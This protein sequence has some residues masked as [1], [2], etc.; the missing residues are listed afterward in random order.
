MHPDVRVTSRAV[1][2]AHLACGLHV[3][4]IEVLP[5]HYHSLII[6]LSL[7]PIHKGL[8]IHQRVKG[9][10][11]YHLLRPQVPINPQKLLL[12]ISTHGVQEL[13]LKQTPGQD[14]SMAWSQWACAKGSLYN[15]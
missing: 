4:D 11:Y 9:T 13:H 2:V 12:L 15:S 3:I 6:P 7:P 14:L 5:T 1:R 10:D 8:Q